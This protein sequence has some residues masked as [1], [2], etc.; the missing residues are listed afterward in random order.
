MTVTE[1]A[2]DLVGSALFSRWPVDGFQASASNVLLH[3]SK[4]TLLNEPCIESVRMNAICGFQ[5]QLTSENGMKLR[6]RESRDVKGRLDP[7]IE[8]MGDSVRVGS[9]SLKALKA[10]HFVLD[11]GDHVGRDSIECLWRGKGFVDGGLPNVEVGLIREELDKPILDF[12]V[13]HG[14]FTVLNHP[15]ENCRRLGEE[16]L[17]L[18][19]IS[20]R[21]LCW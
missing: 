19:V 21:W 16:E 13:W 9:Q 5:G 4:S 8:Q 6:R 20:C 14:D 18:Q 15:L 17:L 2:L 1:E 12:R 7:G 10:R 11:I 3:G